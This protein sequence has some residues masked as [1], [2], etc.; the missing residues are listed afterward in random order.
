M[1]L[2]LIVACQVPYMAVASRVDRRINSGAD[3]SV[4]Q[5]LQAAMA[6][7]A[8]MPDEPEV[9]K[10]DKNATDIMD[11]ASPLVFSAYD[12]L[13]SAEQSQRFRSQTRMLQ[14]S[15]TKLRP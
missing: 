3:N 8:M 13:Q 4:V 1:L 15:W 5:G 7:G 6:M 9:Q 12:M 10:P 11:K 14:T 2:S